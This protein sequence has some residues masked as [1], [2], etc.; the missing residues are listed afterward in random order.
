MRRELS[1]L[2]L[3]VFV[4][5]ACLANRADAQETCYEYRAG[6]TN[7]PDGY[8][9]WFKSPQAACA[10]A[11]LPGPTQVCVG[12]GTWHYEYTYAGIAYPPSVPPWGVCEFERRQVQDTGTCPLSGDVVRVQEELQR[13][14]TTDCTP[15]ECNS[16]HPDVGQEFVVTTMVPPMACN[17][18]TQCL[19]R[20]GPGVCID[21]SCIFTVTHTS[22]SCASVN[23]PPLENG[24]RGEKCI[25]GGDNEWC[26]SEQGKKNCG[27]LNGNFTCLSSVE[28]DGCD[29]FPDGSR[30]CGP[31]APTPPAPDNG[32]PGV[33]AEPDK[34]LQVTHVNNQT[35]TVNYYNSTTVNNSA[36]DPGTS[37]DNPFD[38]RDDG[39][40]TGGGEGDDENPAEGYCPPGQTCDEAGGN[41]EFGEVCTFAECAEA[42]L[43]RIQSAPIVEAVLGVG[44][45][46]PTGACPN[47]TLSAFSEDYSL[48]GPMCDI[49]EDI[50]PMLSAMFLIIWGW[51]ATRI[52]LSA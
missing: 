44:V 14:E 6:R 5:A 47:W 16:S 10:A 19:M 40:G 30:V 50:A 12:G 41:G 28:P 31:V 32:T 45:A 17:P 48:S 24:P 29:V 35:T 7:S 46:M 4:T 3:L 11:A 26:M 22:E 20:R 42:F 27:F 49:F 25:E 43:A 37:G 13:R 2:A 18:I 9:G 36:R 51:I 1:F 21:G 38:G 15:G 39:S 33:P 52:V 23:D 8:T 34:E